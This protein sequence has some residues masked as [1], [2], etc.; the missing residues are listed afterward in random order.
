MFMFVSS[1]A[2][3]DYFWGT[4]GVCEKLYAQHLHLS[5]RRWHR[6]FGEHLTVCLTLI[7]LWKGSDI[8]DD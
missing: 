4:L 2:A 5:K 3:N 8:T 1:S 7:P 6:R